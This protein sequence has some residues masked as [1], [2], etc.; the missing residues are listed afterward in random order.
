MTL[1][2]FSSLHISDSADNFADSF[3]KK[4][5]ETFD[6]PL[7]Q[8]KG[9]ASFLVSVN[10]LLLL[11]GELIIRHSVDGAELQK[12][13]GEEGQQHHHGEESRAKTTRTI[14]DQEPHVKGSAFNLGF[15][16]KNLLMKEKSL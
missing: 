7:P 3:F 1:G 13:A 9:A 6:L 14:T 4:I 16:K 5:L 2:R 15:T 11:R 10:S 12:Q 8:M